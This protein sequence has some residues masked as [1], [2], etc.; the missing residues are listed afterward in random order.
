[1]SKRADLGVFIA[2]KNNA[3][4]APLHAPKPGTNDVVRLAPDVEATPQPA[5]PTAAAKK[6]PDPAPKEEMVLLN[7]RVPASFRQELKLYAAT[8]GKDMQQIVMEGVE[9]H[10]QKH[11]RAK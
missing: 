9:L 10:R 8:I 11:G 7:A 5:K 2:S 1:M 6:K 3:A 4:P